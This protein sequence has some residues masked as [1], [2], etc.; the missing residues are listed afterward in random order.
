[1]AEW[2]VL[3]LSPRAEGEAPELIRASIRHYLR[4]AEVFL[5]ASTTMAGEDK[6]VTWLVD[7]YVFIRRDYPNERYLRLVDTKFVQG[8]V[9]GPGGRLATVSDADI[10]RFRSQIRAQEDQG[11]GVNDTVEVTSG[12]YRNLRGQVITDLA[13]QDAV[14]VYIKLRSKESLVML[15]RSFLRLVSKAA[16]PPYVDRLV[17]LLQ[18]VGNVGALAETAPTPTLIETAL[19]RYERFRAWFE[20]GIRLTHEHRLLMAPPLDPM[21]IQKASAK[22][23]RLQ[24][25]IDIGAPLARQVQVDLPLERLET[26]YLRWELLEDW[27]EK[28]RALRE[29]IQALETATHVL[30]DGFNLACRCATAPGL[31]KLTDTQGRPTGAI[32][33]FLNSLAAWKKTWPEAVFT[34]VW[35]GSSQR[36]KALYPGYKASRG[37]LGVYREVEWL[38]EFLPWLGVRQAWHPDEEAD[39]VI[40]TLAAQTDA[41]CLIITT[42]R[43][44]LQLVDNRVSVL[45]PTNNVRFTPEKVRES[46]GVDPAQMPDLRALCGDASDEIP[47]VQGCGPKTAANLIRLYGSVEGVYRSTLGGLSKG[48]YTALKA[49][50]AQVRLNLQLTRLIPTLTPLFVEPAVD[51]DKVKAAL[52]EIKMKSDR[53]VASFFQLSL[54]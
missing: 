44:L 35:D 52:D 32:L 20:R 6:V 48:V 22:Y 24:G 28:E 12:P 41:P 42:D 11:I 9:L 54:L 14:Q 13:D 51:R 10:E 36:R 53:I 15:P 21:P 30:I 50:Q 4:D 34:V 17:P 16:P 40:A 49:A 3:E 38:R 31:D 37:A 33:G 47:N 43:D 7:G 1:M 39:D 25:W 5:P 19:S 46:F 29:E 2:V 8:P 23:E 27:V 26:V 45:S 18:W